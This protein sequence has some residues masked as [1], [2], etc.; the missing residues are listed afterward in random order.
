MIGARA[1]L[2]AFA[3]RKT[4]A[5]VRA[6]LSPFTTEYEHAETALAPIGTT[7]TRELFDGAFYVAAPPPDGPPATSLVFVQSRDGNT[8]AA[9]PSALGGGQTDKH[10]IY[11]GLS[12]V[13]AD[14]VLAGA[15]TAGSGD[16]VFS[17]WHPELVQLR[18]ALDLPRH[19][20]QVVATRRGVNL[21]DG[22]M[23][24]VPDVPVILLTVPDA[25]RLMRDALHPRP[26]IEPIVMT[27]PDDLESAFQAL[28]T[29]G[30]RRMSAVGGR[31]L[32]RS[33]IDAGLV[34]DL[35][36]TTAAKAGG[37][38]NT[39]LYPRPLDGHAVV[40]KRG[41]GPEAGVVFEHLRV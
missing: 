28:R 14:A 11:E 9:D 37:E 41:T 26:W 34:Q 39:P 13:A 22:L 35:Y 31:T 25:V 40:R 6:V 12:R 15:D 36:L 17:V 20:V 23:F 4:A 24:N 27:E 30:I 3:G 21:E 7:W 16:L 33:L 8:G 18:E 38:P 5:A 2:A 29:M 1:R 19:P 32:A 10:L